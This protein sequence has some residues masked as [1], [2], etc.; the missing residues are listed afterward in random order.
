MS[1]GMQDAWTL[2]HHERGAGWR[3]QR[4]GVELLQ[5]YARR[6]QPLQHWSDAVLLPTLVRRKISD[7]VVAQA[8][9]VIVNRDQ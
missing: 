6:H 4:L 7:V 3:A 1:V 2:S 5:F 8:A 9:G